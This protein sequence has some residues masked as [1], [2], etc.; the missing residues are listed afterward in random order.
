[1]QN[2][3][4]VNADGREGRLKTGDKLP[5]EATFAKK[6]SVSHVTVRRTRDELKNSGTVVTYQGKE[7]VVSNPI[8][9]H[10]LQQTLELLS[11]TQM[12]KTS[13]KTRRKISQD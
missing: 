7:C 2:V 12:C 13:G 10:P 11:F 5:S 8:L 9:E 3:D 4:V 6:Y 1:M